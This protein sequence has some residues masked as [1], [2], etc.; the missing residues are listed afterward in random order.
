MPSP[1]VQQWLEEGSSLREDL[2]AQME[3]LEAQRHELE[4]M[5]SERRSELNLLARILDRAD[6]DKHDGPGSD[7]PFNPNFN[8]KAAVGGQKVGPKETWHAGMS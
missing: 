8:S 5:L 2:L 7:D 3:K 6:D 4:H 1:Q